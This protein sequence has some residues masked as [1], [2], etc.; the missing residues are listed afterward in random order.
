MPTGPFIQQPSTLACIKE[1]AARQNALRRHHFVFRQARRRK[2][3]PVPKK[4]NR[5]RLG[6][7]W[8]PQ[9]TRQPPKGKIVPV[10]NTPSG[11]IR[12]PHEHD[13]E[14]T[15]D[16]ILQAKEPWYR[17]LLGRVNRRSVRY[18]GTTITVEEP[19]EQNHQAVD[20][21]TL[22]GVTLTKGITT[23][24][25]TIRTKDGQVIEADGLAKSASA[26]LHQVLSNEIQERELDQAAAHQAIQLAP[27][28]HRKA[29][30]LQRALPADRYIRHSWVRSR[31]NDT[32]QT[33][34]TAYPHLPNGEESPNDPQLAWALKIEALQPS[35]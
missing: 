25:L 9:P 1:N 18:D 23:N 7:F 8:T 30:E 24:S 16:Q 13:S 11:N 6:A 10:P 32:T 22:A 20:A 5:D 34:M 3:F 12:R 14:M 29:D 19:H 28:I 33:R 27:V 4:A 15:K 26:A 2:P 17:R 21:S 35:H 31:S